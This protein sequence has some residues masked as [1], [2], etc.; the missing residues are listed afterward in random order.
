M[1][2]IVHVNRNILAANIKHGRQDPAI[3]I[4]R[5][6]KTSN[7]HSVEIVGPARMV[8]SPDAPLPCGA[9]VWVECADAQPISQ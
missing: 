8:Q 2:V 6:R 3:I 9:R 5:G 7:A 1:A 4:R